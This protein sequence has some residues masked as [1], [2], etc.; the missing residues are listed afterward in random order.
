MMTTLKPQ[1]TLGGCA[2]GRMLGVS[3]DESLYL[4]ALTLIILSW[5]GNR[6]MLR[7]CAT[8]SK[9]REV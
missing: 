4:T 3:F 2:I 8:P 1:T 7:H 6:V 5:R 9:D